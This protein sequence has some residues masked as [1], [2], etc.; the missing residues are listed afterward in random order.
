MV[1]LATATAAIT[2]ATSGIELIDK[3]VDQIE[4]FI[5]KVP[6]PAVP[7]VHGAK[8]EKEGDS[9]VAKDRGIV[10]QR[11]TADDLLNLP[12]ATLRHVKVMERSTEN[13]YSI[14][15]AVYP[16]LALALDPIA[17]AKTRQQLNA[18]IVGMKGDLDGILN[19]L[20]QS[21]LKLS[22]HYLHIRDVLKSV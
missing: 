13:H 16:Q 12:E 5:K 17:E 8:I 2:A 6:Q 21:G 18:V 1:D 20:E 22:D 15:A 11:I 10:F 19:F 3:I 4:S 7:K 9:I 14:W